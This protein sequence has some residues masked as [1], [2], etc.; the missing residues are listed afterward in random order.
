M[1]ESLHAQLGKPDGDAF[2]VRYASARNNLPPIWEQI[3]GTEPFLSDHGPRHIQNVLA[4][5]HRL[6]PSGGPLTGIDLYCL[7]LAI[8]FHD[9][10]NIRGREHHA[11]SHRIAEVYDEIQQGAN[12]NNQEKGIVIRIA[13]A[14]TGTGRD[15]TRDTLRDFDPDPVCAL[16]GCPVR[17]QEIAAVL[18]LADELAEGPQRTVEFMQHISA[19]PPEAAKHHAYASATDIEIDPLNGRISIRYNIHAVCVTQSFRDN[20]PKLRQ[21]LDFIFMRLQKLDQERKYARYYCSVL[22]PI[23]AV[24]AVFDFWVDGHLLKTDLEPLELDDKVIPG[25]GYKPIAHINPAY[26]TDELL[27]TI[28]RAAV[29]DQESAVPSKLAAGVSQPARGWLARLLGRGGQGEQR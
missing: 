13:S 14:H 2:F 22:D 27:T 26:A 1:A 11:H 4:N 21:L 12:H 3:R 8:L 17:I 29:A 25:D 24:R 5:A 16:Q 18:R 20:L 6:L 15:G 9:V 7:G 23:K 19:Y 28:Q 10:G